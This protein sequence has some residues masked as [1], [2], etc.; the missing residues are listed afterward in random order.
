MNFLLA[1]ADLSAPK[2]HGI[3][4]FNYWLVIALMMTGLYLI[5]S[6]SNMVKTIIGLNFFQVSVIMFYVSMGKVE[7][8][9]APILFGED[10]PSHE[11]D[12]QEHGDAEHGDAEHGALQ[13]NDT[14]IFLAATAGGSTTSKSHSST[15][16]PATKDK[17]KTSFVK[18]PKSG[19]LYSNPLPHVL[20]LTA[21]VVGVATTALALSLVVRINEAF[22]TI[23]ESE[24]E[25]KGALS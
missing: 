14:E 4:V 16:Q 19:I 20:M 25:E 7:Q 24:L 3:G 23:E 8:G 9:T 17:S 13:K 18:S 5:L 6:K 21:I 1:A 22:G 12:H 2:L 10:V 15:P 11:T